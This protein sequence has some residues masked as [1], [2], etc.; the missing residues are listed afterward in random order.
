MDAAAI[1]LNE[2][3]RARYRALYTRI[4]AANPD[5]GERFARVG[6]TVYYD[7]E[8]DWLIVTIGPPAEAATFEV[9]DYYN[10]R[11]DPAT[12]QIVATEVT[13]LA[14]HVQQYPQVAE[15]TAGL[16]QIGLRAPGTYVPIT[17]ADV[18]TVPGDMPELIPA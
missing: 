11:Y 12:L 14:K 16:V 8:D 7:P 3:Q 9:T 4:R 15:A 17:T 1:Q 2:D 18:A 6:G 13:N 5:L 10:W